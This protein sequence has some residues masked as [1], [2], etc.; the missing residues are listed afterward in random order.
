MSLPA[1]S[2]RK[3][4]DTITVSERPTGNGRPC[5]FWLYDR[6]RG[7]NLAMGAASVEEAMAEALRYYQKRLLEVEAAHRELS[8]KVEAFVGQFREEE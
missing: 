3:F 6:T 4:G 7:M 2:S 5:G 8:A 1:I